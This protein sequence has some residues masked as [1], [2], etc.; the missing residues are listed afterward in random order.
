MGDERLLAYCGLYCGDCAGYSGEIADSAADLAQIL[1]RYRFHRTAGHLFPEQIS[2]YEGFH[3][4][5]AFMTEL[6]C[7]KVCRERGDGG[8]SCEI[9]VCCFKRGF[10]ACCECADFG[11][12]AKLTSLEALHGD[13]CVGNL[14]AI[15]E[16]GL[17]A[18][19]ASGQRLWFG[20]EVDCQ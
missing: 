11:T 18:W 2:D 14:E 16:M 17:E 4:T 20:S 3:K 7:T 15:Q 10:Y 8:T 6:R 5:L 9:R 19:I 1:E 13:A 12:C